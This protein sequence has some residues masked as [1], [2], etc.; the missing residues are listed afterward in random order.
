[1]TEA[2]LYFFSMLLTAGVLGYFYFSYFERRGKDLMG[3]K[4][5]AVIV[6]FSSAAALLFG[7]PIK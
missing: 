1:M 3:L 5:L 7:A 6:I 4:I 2:L